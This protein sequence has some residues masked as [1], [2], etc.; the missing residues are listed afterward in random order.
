MFSSY[1]WHPERLWRQFSEAWCPYDAFYGVT[2]GHIAVV[3]P[4]ILAESQHF[5]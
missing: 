5:F 4:E 1:R 2:L 3:R